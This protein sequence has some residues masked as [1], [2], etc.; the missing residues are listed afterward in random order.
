MAFPDTNQGK[1]FIR[2]DQ[3]TIVARQEAQATLTTF[4]KRLRDLL[5]LKLPTTDR[6]PLQLAPRTLELEDEAI[7]DLV[8][9]FN[10]TEEAHAEGLRYAE[11]RAHASKA[12]EQAAR[13]AGVLTLFEDQKATCVSRR[14]MSI[15]I[16][17]TNFYLEEALRVFAAGTVPKHM[18]EAERLR[19][20]LR[21]MWEEEFVDVSAVAQRGPNAL[22]SADRV[23]QL[24]AVL[25][26]YGWLRKVE[27]S[28][29]ISGR[30]SR[31]AYQVVRG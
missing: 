27:G 7:L 19:V 18:Q 4:K 24:F 9:F 15:A 26:E 16:N 3:A 14:H 6:D 17:L 28:H 23:K 22:R 2:M 13:I 5:N 20:W 29:I 21:D 8:E 30:K 25:K 10:V 11:V 12:A 31:R 1:R